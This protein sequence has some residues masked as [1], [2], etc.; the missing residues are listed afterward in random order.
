MCNIP[1]STLRKLNGFSSSMVTEANGSFPNSTLELRI[2]PL[3][4][5]TKQNHQLREKLILLLIN[6]EPNSAQVSH[7]SIKSVSKIISKILE[8]MRKVPDETVGEFPLSTD[9]RGGLI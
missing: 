7:I 8:I 6:L 2:L 9:R 1:S 5:S 4:P 3:Y